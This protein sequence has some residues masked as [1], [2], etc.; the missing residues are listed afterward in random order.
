MMRQLSSGLVKTC[1]FLPSHS[2]RNTSASSRAV[3]ESQNLVVETS[4]KQ[5]NTQ[6]VENELDPFSEMKQ[7]FLSFK[8]EQYLENMEYFENLAKEQKPKFMVIA[9]ADSRVCPSSILGFQ[10]GEAFVVRNIANLVP[11]YQNGPT[12]ANAALEFAVNFLEVQNILVVGHSCCGGIKALMSMTD[13]DLTSSNFI[14]NWVR[15]GKPAR[16]RTQANASSL[17]F[18]QQCQHCE[19]VSINQSLLNLLSYPWIEEKVAKRRISIHGGYYNF[20]DCTFE[21]WTL[22]YKGSESKSDGEYSIKNREFWC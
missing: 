14:P 16:I 1:P 6:V 3:K 13:D 5:R 19:K 8:K 17:D 4:N 22:D 11:P 18:D 21:K 10:P 12:E 7:R 2:H 20:V 15:N 9:C